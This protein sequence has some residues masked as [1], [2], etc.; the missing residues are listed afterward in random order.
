MEKRLSANAMLFSIGFIF[1][2]ACTVGAFFYGIEVGA[3]QIESKYAAEKEK[4]DKASKAAPYQQQDLVSFYHTVFLPYREFQ[5]EWLDAMDKLSK[6]QSVEPASVFKELSSLAKAKSKEASSVSLQNSPLLGDAQVSYIRSLKMFADAADKA[7]S[8]SKSLKN[9]ELRAAILKEKNYLSAVS[10]SLAAQQAYYYA[11][12]KWSASVNVD[13]PSEYKAGNKLDL[14]TWKTLPITVKNKLMSDQ[15]QSRKQLAPFYPHDLTSRVDEFIS[16]GQAAV[17]KLTTVGQ[18]VDLL[19]DTKA[20]RSG[21]FAD[22][23]AKL[24]KGAL[25]PQLPFFTSNA[26]E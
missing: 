5:N 19:L 20:V 4:A 18:I 23:Q 11:M 15:L 6:E 12:L 16:S 10:E 24:Y 25:L 22:N 9:A 1:M 26:A 7:S 17:M 3:D 14:T 8:S 2:L 13:I 21:D